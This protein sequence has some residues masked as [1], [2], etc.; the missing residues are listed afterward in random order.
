MKIPINIKNSNGGYFGNSNS[1]LRNTFPEDGYYWNRNQPSH[2]Q[3]RKYQTY[4]RDADFFAANPWGYVNDP[5]GYPLHFNHRDPRRSNPEFAKRRNVRQTESSEETNLKAP[6]E[7]SLAALHAAEIAAAPGVPL[8]N[9]KKQ[10]S[11]SSEKALEKLDTFKAERDKIVARVDEIEASISTADSDAIFAA[12]HTL[13]QISGDLD[14]LQFTGLDAVSTCDLHSGKD[15]AKAR[16]KELNNLVESLQQRVSMLY[17]SISEKACTQAHTLAAENPTHEDD[18][19]PM[20]TVEEEEE[21]PSYMTSSG[22]DDNDDGEEEDSSSEQEE[23]E[24]EELQGAILISDNDNDDKTTTEGEI[25]VKMGKEM[26]ETEA[27][28]SEEDEIIDGSYMIIDDSIKEEDTH[29]DSIHDDD[30]GC[31]SQQNS[32]EIVVLR[33]LLKEK[34]KIIKE[35]REQL[36][37]QN[38]SR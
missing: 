14:R 5:R 10:F 26:T 20:S 23:N 11:I 7:E 2:P 16:R 1:S 29:H 18:M 4:D 35:L 21:E 25:S 37:N 3:N 12:K 34:D 19:Q 27:A 24:E 9:T 6:N 38:V 32:S 28:S 36:K 17:E 8:Q 31:S 33:A 13:A 30:V 22:D 15:V